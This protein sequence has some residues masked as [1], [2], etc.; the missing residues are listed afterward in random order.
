MDTWILCRV[1]LFFS[2]C[3]FSFNQA[4]TKMDLER[5]AMHIIHILSHLKSFGLLCAYK[6]LCYLPLNDIL[7]SVNI[8]VTVFLS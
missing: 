6:L 4:R 7:Q 8:H 3:F 5:D 2:L 1:S